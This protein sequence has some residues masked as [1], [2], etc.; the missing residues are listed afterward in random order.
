MR[1]FEVGITVVLPRFV[2]FKCIFFDLTIYSNNSYDEFFNDGTNLE[3]CI[4]SI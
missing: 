2:N 4:R 3:I 1:S